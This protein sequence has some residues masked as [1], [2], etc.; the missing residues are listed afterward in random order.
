M[1]PAPEPPPPVVA[2]E[3]NRRAEPGAP[4]A[5]EPTPRVPQQ[6]RI[7]EPPAA[8][9]ALETLMA[10]CARHTWKPDSKNL[11]FAS[12]DNHMRGAEEFRTLRSRLYQIRDR[13]P[14]RTVL[15]ASAFPGEGKTFTT[16]NLGEAIV[17]QHERRALVI[18]ADL[19][20]PHLHAS[21]G[22]PSA[23]GLADYLSG[24][25]DEFSIIQR[26]PVENL[27]LI[28]GGKQ[29]SNPAE[30]IANGRLKMLL[31]RVAPVFDWVL[32]D[33]PPIGA[34]SDASML[35]KLCDG[36]VLV[37]LAASTPFD[38]AVKAREEFRDKRLLGVVLNRVE[39]QESYYSYYYS[40]YHKH[41]NGAKDK[42]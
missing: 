24:E 37:V 17:R 28:P 21:L 5:P 33:S 34:V 31:E 15:I 26:G 13:Q 10:R 39:P 7:G 8:P 25:V 27:F 19:R 4:Q 36:V 30:L 18:D 16:V 14:L 35:A 40:Y 20:R 11:F 29:V 3:V 23:P 32:L 12:S 22:A 9:I 2:P 6:T 41:P 1:G 42:R 38:A